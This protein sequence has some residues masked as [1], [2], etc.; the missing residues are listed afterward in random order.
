MKSSF[1]WSTETS[2]ATNSR[3]SNS[4]GSLYRS[5]S[6]CSGDGISNSTTGRLQELY[7]LFQTDTSWSHIDSVHE[8]V[9][10]IT[11]SAPHAIVKTS[12]TFIS[13]LGYGAEHIFCHCLDHYIDY[14][15]S[16]F[17]EEEFHPKF[18]LSSF[19][20][21]IA[22]RGLAHMIIQLVNSENQPVRCSVH[23]FAIGYPNLSRD[24][25]LDRETNCSLNY[26]DGFVLPIIFFFFLSTLHYFIQK[27]II[28]F[29]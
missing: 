5:R 12:M 1:L 18:I 13:L 22:S 20:D 16:L 29:L 6:L 21:K 15:T 28:I 17:P 27:I 19:Y 9:L 2:L 23:G 25:V 3:R 8:P 11:A 14:D 26:S 10:I 4:R 7:R 24:G